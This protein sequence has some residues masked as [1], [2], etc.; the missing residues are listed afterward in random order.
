MGD[1]ARPLSVELR[2]RFQRAQRAWLYARPRGA[3][4]RFA[5]GRD[6]DGEPERGQP[7]DRLRH[8]AD[9]VRPG[10][11]APPPPLSRT[12]EPAPPDPVLSR[13]ERGRRAGWC[14]HRLGR[15]A[16][17]RLG[18]G[19]S[20]TRPRG[21]CAAARPAACRLD[22]ATGAHRAAEKG[23]GR[24]AAD[25]GGGHR[26]PNKPLGDRAGRYARSHG[27]DRGGAVRRSPARPRTRDGAGPRRADA[28]ARRLSD[29]GDIVRRI[30]RPQLFRHLHGP[31]P[32]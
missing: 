3:G 16:A 6:G 12:A 18:M 26:D 17:V 25:R 2:L 30:A 13:H 21:R 29:A 5:R 1:A 32:A 14:V 9:A 15:A 7:L 8:R 23:R 24:H 10:D 4:R 19:T 20:H 31:R 11:R 27:H 22:G 28:G